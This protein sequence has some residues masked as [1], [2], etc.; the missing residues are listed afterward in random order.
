MTTAANL[1]TERVPS[2]VRRRHESTECLSA[3]E[4]ATLLGISKRA[5]NLRR[6]TPD[7]KKQSA[8]RPACYGFKDL[9]P[10]Y[11]ERLTKK[12]AENPRCGSF[13]E[14]L[15]GLGV[16]PPP[17]VR[18]LNFLDGESLFTASEICLPTGL[19]RE[20]FFRQIPK[21]ASH[22]DRG[23]GDV[24]LFD[25][26]LL[27]RELKGRLRGIDN[28]PSEALDLRVRRKLQAM[29]SAGLA[30]IAK[31]RLAPRLKA[32][33]TRRAM[34]RFFS[35][36][37]SGKTNFAA[38]R[39]ASAELVKLTGELVTERQLRRIAQRV[40]QLG[41]PSIAPLEAYAD[42]KSVPHKMLKTK[43]PH[44]GTEPEAGTN[45]D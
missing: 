17:P 24:P 13:S 3:R 10:D 6:I 8:D 43:R 14:I 21:A 2:P 33:C 38:A 26:T 29:R 22:G 1:T 42:L 16:R 9:P 41:G 31:Q 32:L 28:R 15:I 39:E 7:P 40:D 20:F 11:R 34:A 45:G 30:E 19:T 27:P 23:Y 12:L 5:F 37:D 44:H 4:W 36:V 18:V 25:A 35:G